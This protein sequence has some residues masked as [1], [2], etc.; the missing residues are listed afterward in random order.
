LD[1]IPLNINGKVDKRALPKVELLNASSKIVGPSSVLEYKILKCVSKVLNIDSNLLSVTA[2]LETFGLNSL[3][4]IKLV[5]IY[6]NE[7][8]LSITPA[9]VI[10]NPT[11]RDHARILSKKPKYKP[12]HIYS[13]IKNKP[14]L[15]FVH[16][17][18][19]GAESYH[20]LANLID[21]D[22]SFSCIE[23]HNLYKPKQRIKGIKNI[24]LYYVKLLKQH[25][26]RG[27]YNLGGWSYGGNIAYEMAAILQK[28]GEKVNNLFLLDTIIIK[29]KSPNEL[30]ALLKLMDI[31]M[32]KNKQKLMKE[33]SK[34]IEDSFMD[35]NKFNFYNYNLYVKVSKFAS[36]DFGN[37]RPST[38][39][40]K[41]I[42][43][44]AKGNNRNYSISY[45][46]HVNFYQVP[47]VHND[48]MNKNSIKI[49]AKVIK[50]K[51]IS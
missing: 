15:V 7:L 3:T 33:L 47:D 22:I 4:V 18:Q 2:D 1:K 24:A 46:K 14:K 13:Y 29:P 50:K 40:G 48:I 9:D 32:K 5:S 34:V 49:I 11:I 37:Y 39:D 42:Y 30:K 6:K 35:N 16:P 19:G 38:Y 27:P 28:M 12:I 10:N 43:F 20:R 41:I 25:Q 36:E 31:E 51:L 17:G 21:K 44:K 8:K 45:L 23:Y 26:P